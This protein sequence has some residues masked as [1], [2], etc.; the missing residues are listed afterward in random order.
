MVATESNGATPDPA[1]ADN[2]GSGERCTGDGDREAIIAGVPLD[3]AGEAT[4]AGD[5]SR[6]GGGERC[7]ELEQTPC[8]LKHLQGRQEVF[9]H[10]GRMF[11]RVTTQ[12]LLLLLSSTLLLL[13]LGCWHGAVPPPPGRTHILLLSS[14][15]SGSTFAGQLFSQH[16]DVFYLMEPAKHVWY[17]LPGGSP[18]L[19]QGPARNLLHALF[20]CEMAALQ[21]FVHQPHWESQIFMWPMSRALCSPPACEAFQ[22]GDIVR[23]VE[24]Q[25]YC[26]PSPFGKAAEA[27]ITYSHVALKVVRFFQ[28]EALYPLLADPAL[29][30]RII[31]LV[32]DPRAVYASRQ[33]ISL[34]LE[35]LL[36]SRAHNAT[37]NARLVMRKVCHS[38]AGMYLATLRHPPPALRG[39]YLLTRYEDLVRDPMGQ[40]AKWYH[41]TGLASSPR[42]EAWVHNITHW[43]GPQDPEV[44]P[45]RRDASK[46]SQAWRHQ[47]S[48]H[49]VQEVQEICKPAMEVF[50]YRPVSSEEEQWDLTKDLVLLREEIEAQTKGSSVFSDLH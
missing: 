27:C 22:R 45:V 48:F 6:L 35:D 4:G 29:D 44:L 7:H 39:R 11:T 18:E 19:L 21:D 8:S 20:R 46:V 38:Q 30:L 47:L 13:W 34:Y 25:A 10:Q 36:I 1:N 3:G 31:H 5:L 17:H 32:R 33:H 28:L 15:R 16:P 40:V 49:Q 14:W 41:Y 12:R 9:R 2:A 23:P 37:P 26:D 43:S 42:L 24:C 50:G